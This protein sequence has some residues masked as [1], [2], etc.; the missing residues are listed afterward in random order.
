MR[1]P[2]AARALST[3][4]AGATVAAGTPTD[5]GYTLTVS[6][7]A[8]GGDF[9]PFAIA[10]PVGT[11]GTVTETVKGTAG[12]LPAGATA[13]VSGFGG[14]GAPSADGFQV[15]FGG[16]LGLIDV[17]ALVLAVTGGSGFVGET[18][19]GGPIQNNGYIITDTGNHAPDVT[20]AGA[21]FTI[22][23][24]TPFTL[25]GNATDPDGD[26]VTYM[27]EQNDRGAA[28]GTALVNQVKTDGPL[29]RQF[30]KGVDIN[31]VDTLK[32]NSPGLN[33]VSTNPSRTFP[34][35]EQI[36]S[37]NTNAATG[38]CPPAPTRRGDAAA[39][40]DPGV[41]LGV[42]ADDRLGRLPRRPDAE[43]P[44][45]RPRHASRAAAASAAP[46]RSSRSRSSPA[47]SA[48]PR[49]RSPRSSTA[50][51]RR[52]SRGTSRARTSRRSTRPTSRS[53]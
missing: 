48:S 3:W 8:Q 45:H 36:L 35:M 24:R 43:L 10:D 2:R 46:R 41:L 28:A 18:A 16:T 49:R 37:G 14:A 1:R 26:V 33:A 53:A 17:P 5:A 13:A 40:R 51:P 44:P 19:H 47:R 22:P 12:I 6:G 34:D 7:T 21:I 31:A 30:G 4:P 42:P 23:P 27:W 9:D 50:P 20:T 25:T 11:E 32:Y 15:T 52:R 39:D 29:F 38:L